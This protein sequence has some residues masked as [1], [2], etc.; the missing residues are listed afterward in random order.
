MGK[1]QTVP[2]FAPL[3]NRIFIRTNDTSSQKSTVPEN[4]I[5]FAWGDSLPKHVAKYTEGFRVLFPSANQIIVFSAIADVLLKTAKQRALDLQPLV[6]FLSGKDNG[7]EVEPSTRNLVLC[8]SNTG[9]ISYGAALEEFMTIH[10]RPFPHELLV[11]DSTPGS[12]DMTWF[13]LQRWSKAM[14]LGTAGWFPWPF[15]FTQ[16]IWGV[17]L[18]VL[19]GAEWLIG[20]ESAASRCTKLTNNAIFEALAARRLYLYGKDDD[21]IF[22]KDIEQHAA[23]ARNVGYSVDCV[24][25]EGSGHVAHMRLSPARYWS[26]IRESW[27]RSQK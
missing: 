11:L 25:F 13:N 2:G 6:E 19:N 26:A 24:T 21:L 17:F 22:W 8:M 10:G 12:P 23:A 3:N 15:V 5:I 18:C 14:A 27:L 9:G 7:S 1:P 4:V 16:A 20:R